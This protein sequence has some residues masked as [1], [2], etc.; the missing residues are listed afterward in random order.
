MSM[1]WPDDTKV[2]LFF[3]SCICLENLS[4]NN[5]HFQIMVNF[6][7]FVRQKLHV[8]LVKCS[9]WRHLLVDN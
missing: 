6:L 2:E 5:K 7:V 4:A 8:H 1:F 9:V 3:K